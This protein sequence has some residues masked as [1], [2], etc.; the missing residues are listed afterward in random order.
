MP[1]QTDGPIQ[2]GTNER[3]FLIGVL[4]GPNHTQSGGDGD[5]VIIGDSPPVIS[6]HTG[7]NSMGGALDI[8]SSTNWSTAL[9]PLIFSSE[10]IPHTSIH[11]EG[12]G[13]AE[14][15][16]VFVTAGN[17]IGVDVDFANFDSVIQIFDSSGVEL[18]FNDNSS[19]DPGSDGGGSDS[20]HSR[21]AFAVP[22]DGVYTIRI[23]QSGGANASEDGSSNVDSG[24]ITL[25]VQ[26]LAHI[27]VSNHAT[28]GTVIEGDDTINGDDGN[29]YLFGGLGTNSINGGLGN[30]TIVANAG[31]N[32]AGAVYDGGGGVN[33]F[34]VAGSGTLDLT[35]DTFRNFDHINLVNTLNE[36]I[37]MIELQQAQFGFF[38]IAT[39]N[40]AS[41][42]PTAG[43]WVSIH[44]DSNS[45]DLFPTT[46]NGF[47]GP[48]D[49]VLIHGTPGND[50]IFGSN[51]NDI[52]DGGPGNDTID[53][54]LG[55]NTIDYRSANAGVIVDLDLSGPQDTGGGGIDTLLNFDDVIG[56][57]FNDNIS[58]NANDNVLQGM[59]GDDTLNGMGGS[60]TASYTHAAAGVNIDLGISGAQDTGG[61]GM[62]TLINIENATGGVFND[63]IT[64][65]NNDNTIQGLDGDDVL[66][67]F[68]GTN[69]LSYE[70][71]GLGIRVDYRITD[72]QDTLGAGMDT[73]SNFQN[74][75]GSNFD[76]SLTGDSGDN[77]F[78]GLLGTNTIHGVSGN[79]MAMLVG[80]FDPFADDALFSDGF[81]STTI[82]TAGAV[83]T[84]TS[85]DQVHFDGN[86]YD[87]SLSNI[88]TSERD[89][90]TG[91]TMNDLIAAGNGND[92]LRG[93][94]GDDILDGGNGRDNLFGGDGI[95]ILIGGNGND[96]LT[97]GIGD[98]LMIAGDG[99]NLGFGQAGIDTYQGGDGVDKVFGG[100]GN[101]QL[102]GGG[103]NDALFGDDG[104][105]FIF[106]GDG[107]DRLRGRN[108][109]DNLLGGDGND[110][111]KGGNGIDNLFGQNGNDTLFGQSGDDFLNGGA[112]NDQLFGGS[113]ND[114]F[115]FNMF[116]GPGTDRVN[117]FEV[118]DTINLL[119]FGF[120]NT[121]DAA[122]HFVQFGANVRF[123]FTDII[124]NFVDAL[125]A[126]VLAAISFV[127]AEPARDDKNV[128]VVMED[129]SIEETGQTN[130]AEG[131][132]DEI[133]SQQDM[134]AEFLGSQALFDHVNV[135]AEHGMRE[136]Q[137]FDHF[138]TEWSDFGG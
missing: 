36:N 49:F 101:D 74:L 109:N 27:S 133:S 20:L 102:F 63:T 42:G 4:G 10:L 61:A 93:E 67:G 11:I 5:D 48:N 126:D 21:V 9:N 86:T 59:G 58:G 31:V 128:L 6:N 72:P 89:V 24:D 47:D 92:V 75:T 52:I 106:G 115:E 64:G 132:S 69:T 7:N 116:D 41:D 29:D 60:N 46:F 50:N 117:D 65:N 38:D 98:D 17:V 96:K 15:F 110:N 53:G 100:D 111:L 44:M 45:F 125:L 91:T 68:G 57:G 13:E 34:V 87:L 81:G 131:M 127:S 25:G 84:L 135:F 95:D 14:Y 137:M 113:G 51:A 138:E 16:Q 54:Y 123:T 23:G 105:D 39:V 80:T 94:G 90:L 73:I 119:N 120:S 107:N 19:G 71:S 70:D 32:T 97:A 77:V 3:D 35:D 112:G 55:V 104:D 134:V 30:D 22:A 136:I 88:A 8:D 108:D 79:D 40:N 85:I 37:Q 103:G 18:A 12:E 124:I 122:T 78:N 76:D 130:I 33:L 66:D 43:T 26:G 83:D 28:S 56:T 1:I 82:R 129:F 62:D 99:T 118:G 121:G 2:L 114:I